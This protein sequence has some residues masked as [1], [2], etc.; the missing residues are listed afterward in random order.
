MLFFKKK[1]VTEEKPA[2]GT[3][4]AAE[5][6]KEAPVLSAAPERAETVAAGASFAAEKDRSQL[7]EIL[8]EPD[9]NLY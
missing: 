3:E 8:G 7:G 9:A 6:T 2:E 1:T 4:P 5:E